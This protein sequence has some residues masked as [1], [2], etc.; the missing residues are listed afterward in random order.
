MGETEIIMNLKLGDSVMVITGSEKGKFGKIKKI[1]KSSN[2]VIVEGLNMSTKHQKPTTRDESGSIVQQEKPI[3]ISNVMVCD[4]N[5]VPSKIRVVKV[6]KNKER[7]SK[8][9]GE[10][11]M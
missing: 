8:K 9:T 3:H 6:G 7:V 1:V 10:K 4:S 5:N 2:K 11:I